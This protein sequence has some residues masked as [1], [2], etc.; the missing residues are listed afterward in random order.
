MAARLFCSKWGYICLAQLCC[1][2]TQHPTNAW[3]GDLIAS[4]HWLFSLA[5]G[6]QCVAFLFVLSSAVFSCFHAELV[7][8]PWLV[9]L[10]W[11]SS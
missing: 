11:F 1:I 2:L 8:S 6:L 3:R 4:M 9:R 5:V 10:S 7:K